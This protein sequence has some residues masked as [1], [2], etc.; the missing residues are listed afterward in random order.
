VIADLQNKTDTGK[1]IPYHGVKLHVAYVVKFYLPPALVITL[2]QPRPGDHM[3]ITGKVR[4]GFDIEL[5]DTNGNPV[6]DGIIT[7]DWHA[8][9]Y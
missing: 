6:P 8:I 5:I 3:K 1:D 2:Q 9:G 4:E 7:F